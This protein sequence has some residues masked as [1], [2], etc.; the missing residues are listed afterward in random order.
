[1][2]VFLFLF[3]IQ[4]WTKKKFFFCPL[5][6]FRKFFSISTTEKGLVQKGLKGMLRK[7]RVAGKEPRTSNTERC[8]RT[9]SI[10]TPSGATYTRAVLGTSVAGFS[11]AVHRPFHTTAA[12]WSAAGVREESGGRPVMAFTFKAHG[13]KFYGPGDSYSFFFVIFFFVKKKVTVSLLIFCLLFV[14]LLSVVLN[15]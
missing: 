5:R 13:E 14:C 2:S 11:S 3:F 9:I 15:L 8:L 12:T 1:L 6:F 4:N 7:L 10:S